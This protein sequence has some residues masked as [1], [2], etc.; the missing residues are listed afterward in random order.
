M[1]YYGFSGPE[2]IVCI[3][4]EKSGAKLGR[5]DLE[6]GRLQPIELFYT[7]LFNLQVSG[8]KAAMYATSSTL[9]ERVLVID[10]DTLAQEVVRVANPAHIESGYFSVPK[11]IE[12]P[13][14]NDVS[15]HRY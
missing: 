15:A 5:I 12:F 2:E 6:T 10:L 11:P 1:R 3:Y 14:V 8:R 9:A 7:T 4:Y 13:T